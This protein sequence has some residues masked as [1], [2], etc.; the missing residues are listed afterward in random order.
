M[1]LVTIP[2]GKAAVAESM[3]AMDC[4]IDWVWEGS[5]LLNGYLQRY[6]LSL[7]YTTKN[8]GFLGHMGQLELTTYRASQ[9]KAKW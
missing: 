4:L 3:D 2:V 1:L 7:P 9:A 5:V 8:Y 6:K